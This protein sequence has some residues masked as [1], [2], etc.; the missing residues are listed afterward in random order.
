[1]RSF[2]DRPAVMLLFA[3]LALAG[4]VGIGVHAGHAIGGYRAIGSHGVASVDGTLRGFYSHGRRDHGWHWSVDVGSDRHDI[5]VHRP[6]D[7]TLAKHRDESVTVELHDRDVVAV[8]LGDGRLVRTTAGSAY[9]IVRDVVGGLMLVCVALVFGV[10]AVATARV[11][12]GWWRRGV[13]GELRRGTVPR[14]LA[15]L[16][17]VGAVVG[18]LLLCF[19]IPYVVGLVWWGALLVPVAVVV[20]V[21]GLGLGTRRRRSARA[22]LR[23]RDDLNRW[24]PPAGRS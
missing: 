18:F 6:D 17:G 11:R 8:R 4:T 2:A 22:S 5:S 24:G 3:V 20:L 19:F 16:A 1:M 12:G 7:G 10:A 13:P 23:L 15:N 21:L 14:P 9:G